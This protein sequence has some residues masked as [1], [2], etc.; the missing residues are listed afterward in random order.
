MAIVFTRLNGTDSIEGRVREFY[1]DITFD[2]AYTTTGVA[3]SARDIGLLQIVGISV[4][5]AAT[6]AGTAQTVYM[7]PV[8]DVKLGKIQLWGTAGS[9]TGLTE[10][11]NATALSTV[12][13]RVRVIGFQ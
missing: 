1:G 8:Y 2:A 9:A 7:V 4:I 5:G 10:I 3:I 13:I 12:V 11:A 6:V